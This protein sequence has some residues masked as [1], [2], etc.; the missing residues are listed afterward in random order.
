[1]MSAQLQTVL[2]LVIV[3]VAA[4]WLVA[5]ALAKRGKGSC[6]DGCHAVSPEIKRLQARLKKAGK[7]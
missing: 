4:S 3:A 1:M 6:G 2:A 5:R 7:L